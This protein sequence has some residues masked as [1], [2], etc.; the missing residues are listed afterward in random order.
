MTEEEWEEVAD[1][2]AERLAN[3]EKFFNAVEGGLRDCGIHNYSR[4]ASEYCKELGRRLGR[5]RKSA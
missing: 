5:R 3:K 2:V 4:Y 1:A